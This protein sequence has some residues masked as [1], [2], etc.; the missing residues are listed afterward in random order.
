MKFLKSFVGIFV[1][2]IVLVSIVQGVSVSEAESPIVK[3]GIFDCPH[4]CWGAACERN[5]SSV[6]LDKRIRFCCFVYS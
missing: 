2:L 6:I 3:R 5:F 4:D 1:A